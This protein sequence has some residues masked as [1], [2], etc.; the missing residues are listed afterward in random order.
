[1][2][3]VVVVV[4][5]AKVVGAVVGMALPPDAGAEVGVEVVGVEV[6]GV[7]VGVEDV[8]GVVAFGV[9]ADWAG[10]FPLA[11]APEPAPGCSLATTTPISAV[12]PVAA[13]TADR[14]SR[15]KRTLARSRVS[16][17][18]CSARCLICR[19]RRFSSERP[20]SPWCDPSRPAAGPSLESW[21][22]EECGTHSHH[23]ERALRQH[24]AGTRSPKGPPAPSAG[25]SP[26]SARY[27]HFML[28]SS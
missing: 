9:V 3:V 12:A 8:G 6:V 27:R 24:D 23:T 10:G 11:P 5:G 1:V 16:G 26:W 7:D 2:V 15:R 18:L 21:V 17:E 22:V 4:V 25:V 14:V 19:W 20:H 13:R 28:A